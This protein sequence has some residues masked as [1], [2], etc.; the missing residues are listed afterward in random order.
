MV[1]RDADFPPEDCFRWKGH[2]FLSSLKDFL[3]FARASELLE[4]GHLVVLDLQRRA[5]GERAGHGYRAAFA[6]PC[7]GTV[8]FVAGAIPSLRLSVLVQADRLIRDRLILLAG[9]K[10]DFDGDN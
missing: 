1:K 3:R 9:R 4:L 7:K 5:W 10:G 6:R 8:R 2:G